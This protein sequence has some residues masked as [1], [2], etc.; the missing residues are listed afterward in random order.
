MSGSGADQSQTA[1]IS[2][3]FVSPTRGEGLIPMDSILA[4][5]ADSRKPS[6]TEESI[7][8]NRRVKHLSAI[9][10][11]DI[12]SDVERAALE[13]EVVNSLYNHH[14]SIRLEDALEL[15]SRLHAPSSERSTDSAITDI[16]DEACTFLEN[17]RRLGL[18]THEDP[19]AAFDY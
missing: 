8:H 5:K 12:G 10:R 19:N 4:S 2:I 1:T 13:R 6:L 14:P 17:W 9:V 11:E 16:V 7:A 3:Q 15:T 18:H